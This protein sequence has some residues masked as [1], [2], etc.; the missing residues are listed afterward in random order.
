MAIPATTTEARALHGSVTM[1]PSRT[2][3]RYPS[4]HVV[5]GQERG[6]FGPHISQ[7]TQQLP[8]LEILRAARSPIRMQSPRRWSLQCVHCDWQFD[9]VALAA[10]ISTDAIKTRGHVGMLRIIVC[11]VN[12]TLLDIGALEPHFKRV[13]GDGRMLRD[14]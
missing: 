9:R 11:D 12:E 3:P 5:A 7:K 14:W 8:V 4:R 1:S 13:F 6:S 2:D 10:V